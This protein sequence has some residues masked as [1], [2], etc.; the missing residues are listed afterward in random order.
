PRRLAPPRTRRSPGNRADSLLVAPRAFLAAAQPLLERRQSE[1]L[2]IRAVSVEEIYEQFGHGEAGP[3][4]IRAFL[5]YAYQSWSRPSP[6]YVL[7]LGD[8]TYDPKN[9][10]GTG[11]VNWLPGQSVKT[12]Y[13]WT[14]SDPAY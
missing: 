2:V 11:A 7:L 6:R 12:S 5:E 13:L 1:G 8:A 14:V 3:D 10:L 4:A 9:Y